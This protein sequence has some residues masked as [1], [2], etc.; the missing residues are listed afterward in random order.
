MTPISQTLEPPGNRRGS[1]R[2]P[3]DHLREAVAVLGRAPVDLIGDHDRGARGGAAG[4]LRMQ[5]GCSAQ[6]ARRSSLRTHAGG[7]RAAVRSTDS[8]PEETVAAGELQCYRR[9]KIE[10]AACRRGDVA[11]RERIGQPIGWSRDMR[12][13][14]PVAD[15]PLAGFGHA[16]VPW[17]DDLQA[18]LLAGV[19]R[20]DAR[21]PR[22]AG[23]DEIARAGRQ[24]LDARRT[25][26]TGREVAAADLRRLPVHP[27]LCPPPLPQA[28]T[29]HSGRPSGPA[30]ASYAV[31]ARPCCPCG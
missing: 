23:S 19:D 16:I 20:A 11:D 4:C 10:S 29:Y 2:R 24:R 13:Q 12:R 25:E 21:L 8:K 22:S 31:R 3:V 9:Q 28:R 1:R 7:D 30:R 17:R 5:K 6:P 15:L 26:I 18:Q 14:D 27:R